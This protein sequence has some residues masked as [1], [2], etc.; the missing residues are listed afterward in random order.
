MKV[1]IHGFC[2]MTNHYHL[3]ITT[4]ESNL[5]RTIQWLNQSY[6]G[7]INI[8]YQRSGHLF[9]GRFKSV[10]IEAESHLVALTRY[11]HQNPLSLENQGH[12]PP[13]GY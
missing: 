11:I 10:V 3:E 8:R 7:Y 9:Q 13:I 2:L 12:I 4:P 1:I 5:S 6:A